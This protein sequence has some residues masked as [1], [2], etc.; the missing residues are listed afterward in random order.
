M[1][2]TVGVQESRWDIV[3]SHHRS[4]RPLVFGTRVRQ[5]EAEYLKEFE[6]RI[7]VLVGE[8]VRKKFDDITVIYGDCPTGADHYTREWIMDQGEEVEDLRFIADWEKYG[9]GAGP[10]RNERMIKEG[11]PTQA[12]GF[13]DGN[14]SGTLNT[15]QLC[16]KYGI[17]CSLY[18]I[19]KVR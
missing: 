7:P 5:G 18:P 10:M 12:Y 11:K 1:V 14:S 6:R 9:K 16:M 3:M 15:I 19:G 2:Q 17:P 13:W 4:F 8:S